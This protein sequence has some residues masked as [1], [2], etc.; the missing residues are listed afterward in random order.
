LKGEEENGKGRW[1]RWGWKEEGR[2]GDGGKGRVVWRLE[3]GK[4]RS[5][6]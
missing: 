2:D 5:D 3:A 6:T 4:K 1:G